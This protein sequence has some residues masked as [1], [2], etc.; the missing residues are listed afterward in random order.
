MENLGLV[1]VA[2]VFQAMGK[3]GSCGCP[4]SWAGIAAHVQEAEVPCAVLIVLM[5]QLG[6]SEEFRVN[7]IFT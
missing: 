7:P 4:G 6:V 3:Q 5:L 2:Q 1:Q